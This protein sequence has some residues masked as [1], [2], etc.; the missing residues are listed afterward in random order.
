MIMDISVEPLG[1]HEYLVTFPGSGDTVLSRFQAT[2]ATVDQL[3][4]AS[5]DEE[6][7]VAETAVFLA[8]RQTTADLP[9]MI[10]LADVAAAYGDDYLEELGRRL[11]TL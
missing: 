4:L 7:I 3:R 6:R 5:V 2:E 11:G 8:E 10:D 1:D 9:P